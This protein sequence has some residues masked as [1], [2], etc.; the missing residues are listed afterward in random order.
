MPQVLADNPALQA[1][2]ST[3]LKR[4]AARPCYPKVRYE[5]AASA[6]TALAGMQEAGK[7]GVSEGKA[8][9]RYHCRFCGGFHLGRGRTQPV[10]T[11]GAVEQ[12]NV[13]TVSFEELPVGAHPPETGQAKRRRRN[14]ETVVLPPVPKRKPT[15][16]AP[17]QE[18]VIW[19]CSRCGASSPWPSA[20]GRH[21]QGG[22]GGTVTATPVRAAH[23]V[24]LPS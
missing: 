22:C 4:E 16:S 19:A 6:E 24:D 7:S 3:L 8:L 13:G 14:G 18:I 15:P 5:T 11:P 20:S 12:G 21:E 10:A 9:M 23:P 2:R 17:L 1:L